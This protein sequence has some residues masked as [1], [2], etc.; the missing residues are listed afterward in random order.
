MSTRPG[1]LPRWFQVVVAAGVVG[2]LTFAGTSIWRR[3]GT[4]VGAGDQAASATVTTAARA[5]TPS[6]ALGTSAASAAS[7]TPAAA[8][9]A[10]LDTR[11][12]AVLSRD[13]AAYEATIDP[14]DP[15]F[16]RA[17]IRT[18]DNLADVPLSA[19][20]YAV[21][22]DE[23]ETISSDIRS[24]YA[25]DDVY[26]PKVSLRY[27]LRGFDTDLTDLVLR[28]TF[29]RRGE[30]WYLAADGDFD[31]PGHSTGRAIWDFEPVAVMSTSHTLVM[32]PRDKT[33]Y[34]RT[35]AREVDA[36]IP[37]VTA[38]W[39]KDWNERV[40]VLVPTSQRQVSDLIGT[41]T[42]LAHIA[43]VSV[44]QPAGS[45]GERSGTRVIIN[46]PNFDKLTRLGKRVVLTHEVT[47]VASRAVTGPN[48]PAWLVEGF[49]DYVGYRDTGVDT[50]VAAQ[51]LALEVRRGNTP[52]ALATAADFDGDS[53]RLPQA[54]EGSWLACRMIAERTSERTLVAF[55]RA[56]GASKGDK[57]A[58][59]E[60]AM[61]RLLNTT[62][63][64]FTVAWRAYLKAKL[65]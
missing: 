50:R 14:S 53:A 45:S 59:L 33:A 61:S 11:A 15:A 17:Q 9:A 30:R 10:L 3:S 64:A 22:D 12:R 35:V 24:K 49:A 28:P 7:L 2:Q 5:T 18:F 55:Y 27:G 21:A 38:V 54:Y 62:P 16:L 43:A 25:A 42:A 44:S 32:G 51:E 34:L 31:R 26:A 29:V 46:P 8:V 37:R 40:V 1:R 65:S 63:A 60:E 20:A 52:S 6:G 47:H 58:A 13:R 56:T 57:D 4:D 41:R 48:S 39:G 19:W 36:A 23:I